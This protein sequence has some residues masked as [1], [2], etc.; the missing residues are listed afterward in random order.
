MIKP[1]KPAP[2]PMSRISCSLG[3]W[4]IIVSQSR[5]SNEII[6]FSVCR[7]IM[8]CALLNLNISFTRVWIEPLVMFSFSILLCLF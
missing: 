4:R 1:G 3:I 8:L 7:P 5:T 2:L 6:S